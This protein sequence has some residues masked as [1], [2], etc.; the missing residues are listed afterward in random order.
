[1]TQKLVLFLGGNDNPPAWLAGA[2]PPGDFKASTRAR[3][4][5]TLGAA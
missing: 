4:C 2:G 5:G 1:M 3:V